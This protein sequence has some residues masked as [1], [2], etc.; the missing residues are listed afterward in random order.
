MANG[1]RPGSVYVLQGQK[2]VRVRVRSGITDGSMTEVQ[3]DS[4]KEGDQVIIGVEL[5]QAKSSGT[6]LPPGMGG[7][8][9]RGGQ[10]G[11]GGGGGRGR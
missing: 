9:F 3:T 7:P 4:L 10:R 2:P 8:Q 6:Q 11:G 1:Y 5:A